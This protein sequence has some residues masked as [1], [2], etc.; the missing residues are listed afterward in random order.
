MTTTTHPVPYAPPPPPEGCISAVEA[1]RIHGLYR[2]TVA[3]WARQHPGIA[4]RQ[5][6]RWWVIPDRFEAFLAQ[7]AGGGDATA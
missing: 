5:D 4:I 7:R 6:G 1:A 3:R 2:Q